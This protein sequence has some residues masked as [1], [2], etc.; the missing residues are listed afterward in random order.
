MS[1]DRSRS[2]VVHSQLSIKFW[3]APDSPK[4]DEVRPA[5]CPVCEGAAREPGRPLGIIGHG[6]RGRQVRGP[7]GAD[8]R[9]VTIVVSVRRYL[10]RGCA[11]VLTV[12]P[13][14]VVPR[15]H[16]SRPAIA[17]ALARLGLLDERPAEVRRAVS[18]WETFDSGWP[19]L[20][21]WQ[22]AVAAGTLLPAVR[23]A[24]QATSKQIALRVAQ[25]AMAHAP[26]TLREAAPLVRV[27]AGAIAMA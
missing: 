12:V 5:C 6:L 9:P 16:Y 27:Y 2:R 4:V 15:R 24:A 18:P 11:A 1:E 14:E 7:R 23:P 17:L 26:P 8:D 19:T 10:C 21:R 13:A 25:V 3:N 20:G 22:E